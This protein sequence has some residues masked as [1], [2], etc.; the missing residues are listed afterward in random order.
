MIEAL[1]PHLLGVSLFLVAVLASVITVI[2]S[3]ILLWRYRVAV[4]RAMA[5]SA[6]VDNAT[7][8]FPPTPRGAGAED[9]QRS[10]S[11]TESAHHAQQRLLLRY[12]LAALAFAGVL[13]FAAQLIFPFG[14]GVAGWL[15]GVWIYLWPLALCAPMVVR[16]PWRRWVV[17]FF[18]YFACLLLLGAVASLVTNVP[19]YRVG[20]LDLA[21]RSA[22]TP[23]TLA[24][25]WLIANLVPTV[26]TGLCLNR[27]MRAVAPLVLAL[28]AMTLS[29]WMFIYF[30]SYSPLGLAIADG[31]GVPW[32]ALALGAVIGA[33]AIFLLVA[34]WVLGRMVSQYRRG[35]A[36]DQSIQFD[37]IWLIFAA[38]YG[39]W[40]V[41]GGVAWAGVIVLAWL[42]F[43]AVW[44]ASGAVLSR[45][46]PRAT[47]LTFLR[48]FSLGARTEALFHALALDW[49]FVGSIQLITGLDLADRVVH[50][51]QF[52]DF[53]ARRLGR[54]FVR[55]EQSMAKAL[56][57]AKRTPDPDGRYRVNNFY[58]HADTWKLVLP[59]LVAEGDRVV[60]DLR[61]FM[62]AHE[63]CTHELG[64]LVTCVPL[65]RVVLVVDGETDRPYLSRVLT[66]ALKAAPPGT[67]NHG[68]AL[69]AVHVLAWP[70]R[71]GVDLLMATLDAL[72]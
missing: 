27:R 6:G 60:M 12:A 64:F 52:L 39:F 3:M 10:W 63:G 61:S 14:L 8:N 54:H 42:A 24:R 2:A 57:A 48:V 11:L 51:H 46:G 34:W 41:L 49:R 32:W 31:L 43:K 50:P 15:V 5:A 67:P 62:E 13:S 28:S 71:G 40:L 4:R 37:A 20:A 58:C 56:V 30:L 26:L 45:P 36:S 72:G 29:G 21:A 70:K 69:D 9:P 47:G 44:R 68:L 22:M 19:A 18:A 59:N 7:A 17:W 23:F 16:A 33:P 55:D 25:I 35:Y 53:L 65:S 66:D 38:G 1:T